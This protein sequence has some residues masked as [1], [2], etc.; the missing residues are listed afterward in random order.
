MSKPVSMA[1]PKNTV[2]KVISRLVRTESGCWEYPG[3]PDRGGYHRVRVGVARFVVHRLV[4]EH[5]IGPIPRE[6]D[7]HHRCNNRRCAEPS[8]LEPLPRREHTY[9]GETVIAIN[10]AKTHC[11]HGHPLSGENLRKAGGERVCR[12]CKN[13]ATR[14][15]RE[16]R[17]ATH[18]RTHCRL[19]HELTQDNTWVKKDGRRQC[20]LCL[21]HGKRYGAAPRSLPC[22]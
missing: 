13:A 17:K 4:Y 15:S 22:Q 12:T 20:K 1:R 7:L 11:P 2:Q 19:G 14:A 10:R 6:H 5:L 21:A 3:N 16:K 18:P 8:H 9:R